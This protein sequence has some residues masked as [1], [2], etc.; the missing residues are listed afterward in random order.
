MVIGRKSAIFGSAKKGTTPVLKLNFSWMEWF[1]I[2]NKRPDKTDFHLT[3]TTE[4]LK[5]RFDFPSMV[6]FAIKY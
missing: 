6:K 5:K 4:S 3:I 1:L 2:G